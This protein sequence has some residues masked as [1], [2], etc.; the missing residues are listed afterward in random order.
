MA[1]TEY[2]FGCYSVDLF[3]LMFGLEAE[4]ILLNSEQFG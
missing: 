1:V 2:L 4:F 3:R